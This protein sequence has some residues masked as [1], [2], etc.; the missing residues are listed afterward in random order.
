M[1]GVTMLTGGARSGKSRRALELARARA[2]RKAF[3]ATAE[4]T[5]EEMRERIARHRAAR[6]GEFLTVEAPLDLA[7]ALRGLPADVEVAVVDCLT[8]WLGNLFHGR[9]EAGEFPEIGE[10]LTILD[11]PPCELVVVTNELGMGIVPHNALARRFR[12]VAGRLNQEVAGRAV[13]VELLVSGLPAV[14]KDA[15]P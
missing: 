14:L 8:V 3:I 1:A 15:R 2:G 5:D 13:H 10:F 6:G 9:G 12:E 11:D 4:V 7:G